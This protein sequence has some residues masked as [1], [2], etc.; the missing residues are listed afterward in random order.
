MLPGTCLILEAFPHWENALSGLNPGGISSSEVS[1]TNAGLIGLKSPLLDGS[2]S[3]CQFPGSFLSSAASSRFQPGEQRSPAR[4][5]AGAAPP[6]PGRQRTPRLAAA[7]PSVWALCFGQEWQLWGTVWPQA[8]EAETPPWGVH[9]A[10]RSGGGKGPR[11]RPR[12]VVG[13]NQHRDVQK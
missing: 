11:T 1:E 8:P 2:E 3:R 13:K 7:G 6:G 12:A 4:G 5:P 9:P 10:R